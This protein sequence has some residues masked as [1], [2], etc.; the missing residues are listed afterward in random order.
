MEDYIKEVVTVMKRT[1][2]KDAKAAVSN[3][4]HKGFYIYKCKACGYLWVDESSLG[5]DTQHECKSGL[6]SY[7]ELIGSINPFSLEEITRFSSD[8][9]GMIGYFGDSK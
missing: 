1:A 7:F 5:V 4:M 3:F 9:K 6:T 8:L 2:K